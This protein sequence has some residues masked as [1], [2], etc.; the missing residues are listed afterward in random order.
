M[1]SDEQKRVRVEN[2]KKLLKLYPKYTKKTFDNLVTGDET[3]VYYFEPKRKS[4]N[5]IWA[6]KNAKR[7]SIAK[8]LRTVK[9]VLYVIFFDNK[10]PVMQIPVPKGKT[11]TGNFYKNVVI[12]KLKKYYESRRPKTGM[13]YLRLLHNNAPAHKARIVTEYLEAEK[14]TVLPHPPFSP[15]LQI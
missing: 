4:S 1:L 6:S 3:W 14:V 11:V 10:G 9:K 2:A 8:R 12:K 13:K 7:P 5:R 15:F